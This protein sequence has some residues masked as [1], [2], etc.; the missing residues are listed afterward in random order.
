M[1]IIASSQIKNT[2]TPYLANIGVTLFT[3]ECFK[4]TEKT[5]LRVGLKDMYEKYEKWCKKN[6]KD[7][8][9]TQKQFKEELEKLNY[10]ESE[11]KGVDITGKSGKRGYNIMVELLE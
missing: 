8:L 3:T 11:S 4:L 1:N 7:C 10:K 9:K 2:L 6:H 5:N